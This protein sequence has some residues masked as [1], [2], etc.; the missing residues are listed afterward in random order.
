M[1]NKKKWT[2]C[3]WFSEKTYDKSYN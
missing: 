1:N 2:R 3:S